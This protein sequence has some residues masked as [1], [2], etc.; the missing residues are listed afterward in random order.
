MTLAKIVNNLCQKYA[1]DI[2]FN[3]SLILSEIAAPFGSGASAY[4]ASSLGLD[5]YTSSVAAGLLG[6]YVSAVAVFGT[7]WY[8]FNRNKYKGKIRDYFKETAGIL[9]K[10]IAPAT[11]SYALYAPIAAAFTDWAGPS[12]AAFYASIAS[13]LLF[14]VGSNI[15]NQRVIGKYRG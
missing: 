5:D 1:S 13:S 15:L 2:K 7:A 11:A 8:L 3:T 10:N 6:N 9:V 12:R 14:I 4:V